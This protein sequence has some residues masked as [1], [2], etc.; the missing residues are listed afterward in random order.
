[1]NN[2]K[3]VLRSFTSYRESAGQSEVSAINSRTTPNMYR[4]FKGIEGY[5]KGFKG[6]VGV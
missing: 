2:F 6:L 3:Y 5:P 1:M 4:G